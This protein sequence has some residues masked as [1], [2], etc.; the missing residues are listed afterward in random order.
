MADRGS[1]S[2][3]ILILHA[4]LRGCRH[5]QKSV[6]DIELVIEDERVNEIVSGYQTMLK[7]RGLPAAVI[8]VKPAEPETK[9]PGYRLRKSSVQ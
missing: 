4:V 6:I 9:E 8:T 2:F 3:V 7:E 1:T 5:E